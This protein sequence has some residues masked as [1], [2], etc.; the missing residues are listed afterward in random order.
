M[1]KNTG[2]MNI[3][4]GYEAQRRYIDR[5]KEL[6]HRID[7][8][9]KTL[10]PKLDQ[11]CKKPMESGFCG[12]VKFYIASR[13][14]QLCPECL[15]SKRSARKKSTQSE[16]VV[17]TSF[18]KYR[19]SNRKIKLWIKAAGEEE[20]PFTSFK[21][22]AKAVGYG[23][24]TVREWC[25]KTGGSQDERYTARREGCEYIPFVKKIFGLEGYIGIGKKVR[26]YFDG[27]YQDYPSLANAADCFHTT[28]TTLS[29][30]INGKGLIPIGHKFEIIQ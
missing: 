7:A 6:T 23:P 11:G 27:Q 21:E 22:A 19:M 18:R 17:R 25:N 13:P 2:S 24:D 26:V 16:T 4:T 8:P 3:G 5:A 30:W 28:V 29:R 12:M 20:Q 9:V 10:E 15:K 1:S 14:V